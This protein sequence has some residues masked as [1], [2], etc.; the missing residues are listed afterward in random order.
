MAGACDPRALIIDGE[1]GSGIAP[2]R[3]LHEARTLSDGR[4]RRGETESHLV[5][6]LA[7]G[8]ACDENDDNDD[9]SGGIA[10]LLLAPRAGKTRGVR[11]SLFQ[12]DDL[13]NLL[14]RPGV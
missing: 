6:E 13:V 11:P 1:A 5:Y 14:E 7:V 4:A 2:S 12:Q 3:P 8:P 9:N 10:A